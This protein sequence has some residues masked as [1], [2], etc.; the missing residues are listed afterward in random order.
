[1]EVDLETAIQQR[2]DVCQRTTHPARGLDPLSR[3]LAQ[4]DGIVDS[5]PDSETLPAKADREQYQGEFTYR[6]DD[7][8]QGSFVLLNLAEVKRAGQCGRAKPDHAT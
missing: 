2:L 5:F 7:T 6:T 8:E 4:E 3:D 1:M